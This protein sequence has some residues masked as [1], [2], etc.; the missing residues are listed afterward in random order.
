MVHAGIEV[1]VRN[2]PELDPGFIPLGKFNEAFL[3]DAQKPLDVAVERSGGQTAVWHTR[4]HGTP[5]Y[6]QADEYYVER[7]IKTMLWM[8]GGF[9]VYLTDGAMAERMRALYCAS[10]RGTTWQTSMSTPLR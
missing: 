4:I 8:Y 2:V 6:A 5:E 7:L 9:R 3:R 10:G 1:K